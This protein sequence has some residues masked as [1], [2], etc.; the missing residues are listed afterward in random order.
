MAVLYCTCFDC[1]TYISAFSVVFLSPKGDLD[2]VSRT[3]YISTTFAQLSTE[4]NVKIMKDDTLTQIRD[5]KQGSM[6]V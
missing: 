4:R 1:P 5:L 6:A 3:L 2:T